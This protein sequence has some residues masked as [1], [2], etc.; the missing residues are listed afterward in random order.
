MDHLLFKDGCQVRGMGYGKIFF[1]PV[2]PEF[3]DLTIPRSTP[4][5]MLFSFEGSMREEIF[6]RQK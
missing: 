2:P 4:V 5:Y 3:R 6:E 1:C